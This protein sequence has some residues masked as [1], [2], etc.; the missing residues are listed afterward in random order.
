MFLYIVISVGVLS[1]SLR[2]VATFSAAALNSRLY[3]YSVS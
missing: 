1:F 3:L 2:R